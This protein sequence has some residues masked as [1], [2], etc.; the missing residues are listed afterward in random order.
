MHRPR[1][2]FAAACLALAVLLAG[3][4]GSDNTS[5]GQQATSTTSSATT[6]QSA[7]SSSAATTSSTVASGSADDSV[8]AAL[9]ALQTAA[10]AVPN[11]KAFDLDDDTRGGQP[12]WEVKVA[13]GQRQFDLDV[14]ADGA[15]VLNRREDRTPDDDVRK[16]RSVKVDAQRALRLAAQRQAGKV[17]D[18]DLDTTDA[19][20]V[21]WEVDF[22]QPDRST[23]TVT[24]HARTGKVLGTS[25]D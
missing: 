12:S 17:T 19:G 2:V 20:T 10:R 24:I 16:L 25:R 1:F 4:G 23:T 5:S 9:R 8:A 21:V 15:R 3:C 6:N 14:T 22:R 13:S 18:L 7:T 11:G